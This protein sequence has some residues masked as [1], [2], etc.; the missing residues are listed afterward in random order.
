MAWTWQGDG[1]TLAVVVPGAARLPQWALPP[2][3][4]GLLPPVA[5]TLRVVPDSPP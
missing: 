4:F 1:L 3:P 2:P 5:W